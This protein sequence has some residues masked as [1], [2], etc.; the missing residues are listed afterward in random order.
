MQA[1]HRFGARCGK[2]GRGGFPLLFEGGEPLLQDRV[3]G[4]ILDG[5][6]VTGDLA[7]DVSQRALRSGVLVS[8]LLAR[9]RSSVIRSGVGVHD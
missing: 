8:A 7:L 6:H 3:I 1:Q 5:P 9:R 4:T 2:P